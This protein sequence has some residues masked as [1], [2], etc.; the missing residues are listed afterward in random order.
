MD[1]IK[2]IYLDGVLKSD[3]NFASVF[4]DGIEIKNT[5]K[6]N[7]LNSK[8]LDLDQNSEF[9]LL[10]NLTV[11]GIQ[12]KDPE[13][14]DD[15]NVNGIQIKDPA[16]KDEGNVNGIQIKD[17]VIN[18]SSIIL[19]GVLIKDDVNA[20]IDG[21]LITD[22][23]DIQLFIDGTKVKD[24]NFKVVIDIHKDNLLNYNRTNV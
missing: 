9:T 21:V 7:I 20:R 11:N 6:F 15:G 10:Y 18:V 2:S 8:I 13:V 22:E 23:T 4:I 24:V 3:F 16:V 12:I 1:I 17:P 14:K 5:T 19:N